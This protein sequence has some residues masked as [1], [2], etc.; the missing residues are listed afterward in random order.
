[1]GPQVAQKSAHI[2]ISGN[3]LATRT[4]FSLLPNC[5]DWRD[6]SEKMLQDSFGFDVQNSI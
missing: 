1:M 6:K 3:K 4:S 5:K 2:R